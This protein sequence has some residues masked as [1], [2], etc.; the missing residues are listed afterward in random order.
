[1]DDDILTADDAARL[2]RVAPDTVLALLKTSE[3]AG[4]KIGGE[5][6]TTKRALLDYVDG[7]SSQM[8]CC[9]PGMCCPPGT[10]CPAPAT[11]TPAAPNHH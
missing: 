10:C 11:E 3:L 4:R 6:R 2:L 1:M 5:W 9:P 7:M 8:S